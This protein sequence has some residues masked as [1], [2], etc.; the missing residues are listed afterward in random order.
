M[1]VVRSGTVEIRI[2]ELVYESVGA[3]GSS[4]EMALLD[5]DIPRAQRYRRCPDGLRNRRNRACAAAGDHR[6][7]SRNRLKLCQIVVR[8]L[9]ATSS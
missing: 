7:A 9:R 8:R 2:G 5:Q 6:P 3:G 1:F 4:G